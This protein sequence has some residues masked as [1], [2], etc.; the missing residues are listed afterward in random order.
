MDILVSPNGMAHSL[1]VYKQ[2]NDWRCGAQETKQSWS[3][4]RLWPR[5]SGAITTS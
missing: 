4:D 3:L 1:A 5:A 2:N